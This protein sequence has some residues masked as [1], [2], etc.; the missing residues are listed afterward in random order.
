MCLVAL[1]SDTVVD[2][3]DKLHAFCGVVGCPL[4]LEF[5][6]MVLMLISSSTKLALITNNV[7]DSALVLEVISG[8]DN[9]DGPH[10]Q[11]KLTSILTL[12]SRKK[13][14]LLLF[15]NV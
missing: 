12:K 5:Q 6:D 4:I 13:K 2:Q 1:G 14:K 8:K 3:L 7:E 11:E 9:N 15:R 10:L